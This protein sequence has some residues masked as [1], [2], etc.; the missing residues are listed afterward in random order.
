MIPKTIVHLLSGGLDSVTLLYELHGKGERVHCVLF[1][2]GQKHVQELT[3]AK[4]HCHRLHV[5]F[6]TMEIPKLGGLTNENWI[7]PNRNA[8][9]LSLAVNLAVRI[10]A[11]TV[12]IGCNK[13]DEA[14][15]PDCRMAF[16]QLFNTM[17]TTVEI[18]VE[19]CAPYLDW[20]KWKIAGLARD[21]G[22]P[23]NEIWTCYLG[24]SEPCG[25]C[26]ACLKLNEAL[27]HK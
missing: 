21:L 1:D 19:V 25:K 4:L 24:G 17:L 18:P 14:A 20:P 22:V 16:L 26:P 15:F 6:T 10:K 9:M 7:V 23:S 2:Y 5:L 13:D 27:A 11:D 12:T 8:I 3:F